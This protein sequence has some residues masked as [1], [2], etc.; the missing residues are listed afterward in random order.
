[1]ANRRRTSWEDSVLANT[2][3]VGTQTL[4]SIDGTPSVDTGQGRTLTRVIGD[5]VFVSTTVAG[6]WGVNRMGIG[7][8]GC[9]RE[10]FTAGVVPDPLSETE[11]PP[12]GW[13]YR[14]VA[15][16][17]QNGIGTP[18]VSGRV[19]FD[20]RAQRRLDSGRHFLAFDNEAQFG[21]T[22]S[23]RVIGLVRALYLLP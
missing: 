7:I 22:A 2:I 23:Y 10:A 15:V 6:A 12:R 14:H 5:L 4:L 16:M 3:V 21:T 17:S 1:M 18:V 20:I 19:Q 9:S 11:E 13:I 8:G